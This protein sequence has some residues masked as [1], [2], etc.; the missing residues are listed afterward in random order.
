[1]KIGY[2]IRITYYK[3]NQIATEYENYF[4]ILLSFLY[5]YHKVSLQPHIP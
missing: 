4:N 3:S 5:E 2:T 1:M